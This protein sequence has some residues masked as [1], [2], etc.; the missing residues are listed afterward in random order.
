MKELEGKGLKILLASEEKSKRK[1]I[2]GT[3][4]YILVRLIMI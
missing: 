4:Q 1:K 2:S 3:R